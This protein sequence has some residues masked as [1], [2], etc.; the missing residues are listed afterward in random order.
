MQQAW[1]LSLRDAVVVRPLVREIWLQM[2]S[3]WDYGNI[4]ELDRLQILAPLPTNVK[5][6]SLLSYLTWVFRMINHENTVRV[7]QLCTQNTRWRAK[8][9][10]K[11]LINIDF[12]IV[13]AWGV[14][15]FSISQPIS[16]PL[17]WHS[18]SSSLAVFTNHLGH[19]EPWMPEHHPH[20]S[21]AFGRI[22]L[23]HSD[24]GCSLSCVA[25]IS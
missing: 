5:N 4:I 20:G 25:F 2:Q 9:P 17:T 24:T 3:W 1:H 13:L 11:C 18:Y 6:M 22:A 10:S 14:K 8:G 7:E 16:L 21:S 12:F 19:S 15:Y 23:K